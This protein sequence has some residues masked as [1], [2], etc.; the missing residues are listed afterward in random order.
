MSYAE[1][2]GA[3]ASYN[4]H[5]L[6][7]KSG[8]LSLLGHSWPVRKFWEPQPTIGFRSCAEILGASTSYSVEGLSGNS[9]SLNL[10]ER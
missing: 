9:G 3:S 5:V 4:I 2:L 1:I 6:C 10:L 8:S 7:G